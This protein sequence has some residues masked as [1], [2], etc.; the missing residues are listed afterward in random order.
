MKVLVYKDAKKPLQKNEE[1]YYHNLK[2]FIEQVYKDV[3]VSDI[4]EDF[5]IAH[6]ISLNHKDKIIKIKKEK[7]HEVINFRRTIHKNE[8][9][10]RKS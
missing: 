6:F 8:R 2:Y 4:E 9:N 5:D 1:I 10:W 7:E 3:M